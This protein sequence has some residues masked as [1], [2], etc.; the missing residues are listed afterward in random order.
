[1]KYCG[2]CGKES[3]HKAKFCGSC[4]EKISASSSKKTQKV[5]KKRQDG[6]IA[7]LLDFSA[8]KGFLE[9]LLWYG[10]FLI[11]VLPLHLYYEDDYSSLTYQINTGMIVV[12]LLSLMMLRRWKFNV[13]SISTIVIGALVSYWF[14]LY[15]GLLAIFIVLMTDGEKVKLPLGYGEI[16]DALIFRGAIIYWIGNILS[17]GG[18]FISED[19]TYYLFY[20][21]I[22]YGLFVIMQGLFYYIF[23]NKLK[24]RIESNEVDESPQKELSIE[25]KEKIRKKTK[26]QTIRF[27]VYGFIII[28]ALVIIFASIA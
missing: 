4:G 8:N 1:M 13:K 26:R 11:T 6:F 22:F 16:V 9:S 19:D 2:H 7:R 17:A 21:A 14:G 27:F 12:I 15:L 3:I 23:P 20:G 28:A 18:I 25:E 5:A 24:E 10:F